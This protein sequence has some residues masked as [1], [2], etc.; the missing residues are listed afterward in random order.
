MRSAYTA[1]AAHKFT[2]IAGTLVFFL[3]LS[4]VP[5][6]FWLTLLF[7][8]S[9]LDAASLT[10]LGLFGWAEDLLLFL[11]ENAAENT[12]GASIVFLATT[13]WSSTGFFYHLRRSG[14][15]IYDYK[16][17]KHGWKVRIAAVLYTA[18][19]LLFFAAAGAILLVAGIASRFLPAWL[20]YPVWYLLALL[21]GFFSAWILNTYLC[22]YRCRPGDTALGSFLT[23][24]AWLVA[25]GV[26]A[27]FLNFGN[28]EQLYGALTLVVV[29]LIWLYWMMICLTAG[30]VFCRMRM[31]ERR[32]GHKTL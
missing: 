9:A 18:A 16:A 28:K 25:S 12:T 6:V 29:F 20:S 21:L 11:K 17:E 4:L 27:V 7:G 10:G 1:L 13:F 19:V 30:A 22:P 14:E 24:L 32:L 2:T 15:I 8:T 23:A 5:F 3:I 26:F 31:D